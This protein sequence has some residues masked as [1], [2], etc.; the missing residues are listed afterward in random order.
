M[1]ASSS[2]SVHGDFFT[3]NAN[4]SYQ[5]DTLNPY[6]MHP[7]ENPALVLVTPLLNGSNYH[8]WSRSMTVAIR[9]KNKLHFLT[10]SLPRPDDD[11]RDSMAWDRCNTMLMSW[12]TN[13]VEP[14]IAQSVLWM[15]AASDIW[16]ELKDRFYQGD[17]FRISDIQEEI[18]TLKQGDSSISSYYTKLKKLWQELDNF[19]PIPSCD[20]VPTCQA[21]DKIRN[22]RDGDQVIRFLKGLNE[23][24]STVKS[25]IMLMDPLPNICKV[26]SLLVQQERQAVVPLDESKLLAAA[27]L[28]YPGRGTSSNRGRGS[29]AGRTTGGR[30]KGSRVCTH[31][32]MTNH[33]VDNCFKKHGYPPHWQQN[34]GSVNHV[35]NDD[36]VQSEANEDLSNDQDSGSLMFTPEQHKALLALLQSSS[37]MSSHSINHF[38]SK[39]PL[40]TGIICTLPSSTNLESFILDTGATDHVC[41]C[42][43][44]FQFIKRIKPINIKLPNGTLVQTCHAGSISFDQN[45]FLSDVLYIP[46][47][48]FNLI[49]VPKL[50]HTLAC[51]LLFDK[52]KCLIQDL[53]SKMMIGTAELK[54]GL[55]ILT[56]PLVSLPH[57]LPRHSINSITS[58]SVNKPNDHALWH[59]RFGHVSDEKLFE[60][61]KIFPSVKFKSSSLPCD[62]C[63]YAKQKRLPFPHSQHI[64][65]SVFDIVHIDIWGPI[66]TPSMLGYRYF[67]TVV[68]DKSR[69]TWIFLMKY[70]SETSNLI[71]SFVKMIQTQFNIT[72]KCIRFDNGNEFLLRDFYAETGILHQTSCVGTPQQNGIVER[73]HQHI[74]GVTRA[75]LFQSNLPKSFWSHAVSHAI[76]IINRLPT[77]FL[78]N[79]SPY[80]ILHNTLPDF[81]ILKVFGSLCFAS[82]LKAHRLKLDSRSRKC[83]YLGSKTGVKGHILFDLHTKELFLSRDVSFFEHLFPY[84]KISSDTTTHIPT[85]TIPDP[86]YLD[87]L[88]QYSPQNLP[89]TTHHNSPSLNTQSPLS[90][91]NHHSPS[92]SVNTNP[93]ILSQNISTTSLPVTTSTSSLSQPVV[94]PLRRST[95]QTT[96]PAYLQDF[97]CNLV[98]HTIHDSASSVPNSPSSSKYPLSASLTYQSLSPAHTHTSS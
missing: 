95:R 55:Y 61:N 71:K 15:D 62:V 69:F 7:N 39:S 51:N 98:K 37:S 70:K 88:F 34:G 46:N 26:Y 13:S 72:I 27:N 32:G 21:I 76:H 31:C 67:L 80:Q 6:Y 57:T 85:P 66:A 18:C 4:K 30:G 82:T 35:N 90:S 40:G 25:Q 36:E 47:F 77:P 97:H 64:S 63:F 17:V 78:Q 56:T 45:F 83:I 33:T 79:K 11:N 22:Y 96:K 20:C 1:S 23:Q 38:T 9:S 68:D 29:K 16:K 3:N 91:N 59:M 53:Y 81:S 94:E 44:F 8:S 60:I 12:L 84:N 58:T 86:A 48:S 52:S 73:K 41:H 43:Q 14:E 92:N 54:H 49:S 28:N 89:T 24:Y 87:D 50:T 42:L 5:N 10:G 74:L 2:S 75:L 93:Q 65:K 19:R